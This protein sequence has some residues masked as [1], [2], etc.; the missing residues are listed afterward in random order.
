MPP[1]SD[2][3][4]L[5]RCLKDLRERFAKIEIHASKPIVPFR[6]TAVKGTD[7]APPKSGNAKRGTM[8]GASAMN[9]VRCTIRAAPLPKEVW[10]FLRDN[11]ALLRQMN[12]ERKYREE[13]EIIPTREVTDTDGGDEDEVD[14]HG[15][16]IKRPSVKPDEFWRVFQDVCAKAGGEWADMVEKLWAFG[17]QRAGTCVLVDSRAEGQSNS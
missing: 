12:Q 4:S 3:Q 13:A 8:R 7:M 2:S 16:V 9:L 5:Q 10:E 11:L 6:E 17:P 1:D 15:E 14:L